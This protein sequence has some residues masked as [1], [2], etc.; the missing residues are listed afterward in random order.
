MGARM[1][2]VARDPVAE[3]GG[4]GRLMRAP[5]RT[6]ITGHTSGAC[7]VRRDASLRDA[8]AEAR[9]ASER[10]SAAR[11]ARG[12]VLVACLDEDA[13]RICAHCLAHAGYEVH[14]VEDPDEVLGL[15]RTARP[16]VIVTSYPTFTSL[17]VP[18]TALVRH[19]PMLAKTPVLNLASWAQEED[20][21]AAAVGGVSLSLP[22]PVLLENLLAAVDRLARGEHQP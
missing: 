6:V 21:A 22:M 7:P 5:A 2:S 3:R 15:A 20:L 16:D 9:E 11:H 13:R 17:G 8:G 14:E 12:T 4:N 19:D 10:D 1:S 18:V